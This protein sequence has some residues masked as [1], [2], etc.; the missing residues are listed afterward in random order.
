[1][2]LLKKKSP[3][4]KTLWR[5][6]VSQK[7]NP[8]SAKFRIV[9]EQIDRYSEIVKENKDSSY[10]NSSTNKTIDDKISAAETLGLVASGMTDKKTTT[11][12]TISELVTDL[13]NLYILQ[14]KLYRQNP[15]HPI[16]LNAILESSDFPKTTPQPVSGSGANKGGCMGVVLFFVVLIA[17]IIYFA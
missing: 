3:F 10:F 16:F 7:L 17:S 4:F 14:Y 13:H 11:G 1:M 9:S 2:L 12:H 6:L 5:T 8:T 15:Q